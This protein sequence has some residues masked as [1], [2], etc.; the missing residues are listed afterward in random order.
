VVSLVGKIAPVGSACDEVFGDE[1]VSLFPEEE[2]T[3]VSA[4]P[5]RRAEFATGRACARKALRTLGVPL[6]SVPRGEG[7]A[8]LWL[9]GVV[10]SI[11]HCEGYRAA[12]V[13]WST[14]YL[15]LGVD[16]EVNE[17]LPPEIVDL[18]ATRR[19]M[20]SMPGLPRADVHWDRLLFSAKET[21]YKASFPLT[22]QWLDFHD[23]EIEFTDRGYF[24][25]TCPQV[26][27]S[28]GLQHFRGRWVADPDF[29]VTLSAVPAPK[30]SAT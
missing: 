4:V 16:A 1:V 30:L 8:P 18:V 3:V 9:P 25:A 20:A 7:G 6:A 2:A 11:T 12:V 24:V 19:E 21:V 22:R 13:A 15:S 26:S 23:V 27:P 28:L 5:S 17:P 14:T 10:G 29:I